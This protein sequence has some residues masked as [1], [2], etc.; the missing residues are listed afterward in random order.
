MN[1][2]SKVQEYFENK[3]KSEKNYFSV[4]NGRIFVYKFVDETKIKKPFLSK[5]R[6]K[7]S[8]GPN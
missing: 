6:V 8:N 2:D 4:K 7:R 1:F 5:L 3:L